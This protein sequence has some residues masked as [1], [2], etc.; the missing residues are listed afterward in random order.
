MFIKYEQSQYIGI[1]KILYP[2]IIE[3]KATLQ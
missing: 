1:V 3:V 2:K